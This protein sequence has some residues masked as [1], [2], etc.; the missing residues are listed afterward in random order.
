VTAAQL[1]LEIAKLDQ[2]IADRTAKLVA[3]NLDPSSSLDGDSLDREK[4]RRSLMDEVKQAE[5]LRDVLITGYN[6]QN[7]YETRT[8]QVL[9]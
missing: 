2:I 5:E 7:P 4:Y 6:R 9:R 8:R 1:A 3:Y